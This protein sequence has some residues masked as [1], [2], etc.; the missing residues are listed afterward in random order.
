VHHRSPALDS[1]FRRNDI[2]YYVVFKSVV[3]AKA[4]A[5]RY[6]GLFLDLLSNYILSKI[7][8]ASLIISNSCTTI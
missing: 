2:S 3:P 6:P 7:K 1:G 8:A 4:A 5:F